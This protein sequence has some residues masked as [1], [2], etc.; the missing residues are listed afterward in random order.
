MEKD[1]YWRERGWAI[2]GAILVRFEA[3]VAR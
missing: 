2:K 3:N 1:D